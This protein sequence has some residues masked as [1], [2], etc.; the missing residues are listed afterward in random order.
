MHAQDIADGVYIIY[1]YFKIYFKALVN[2][3][4]TVIRL[5]P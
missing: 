3:N 1:I 4:G 2:Y 5:Y